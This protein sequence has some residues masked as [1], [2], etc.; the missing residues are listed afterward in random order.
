MTAG[1][2]SGPGL[3]EQ[4]LSGSQRAA[5][6]SGH[7]SAP[8]GST[9]ETG[10]PVRRVPAGS[11]PC[12]VASGKALLCSSSLG[13]DRVGL[14]DPQGTVWDSEMPRVLLFS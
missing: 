7:L 8:A 10:A 11:F 6:R 5:V 4:G 2:P 13:H 12:C 1:K 14:D 3:K 9:K